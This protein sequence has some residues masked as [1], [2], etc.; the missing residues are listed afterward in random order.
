MNRREI[1]NL[2]SFCYLLVN[3]IENKFSIAIMWL[4]YIKCNKKILFKIQSSHISFLLSVI[5]YF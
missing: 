3:K 5:A 4:S 2:I 1:I